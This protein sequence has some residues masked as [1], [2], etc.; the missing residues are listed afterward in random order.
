MAAV[1]LKWKL[2]FFGTADNTLHGSTEIASDVQPEAGGTGSYEDP[3]TM[4]IRIDMPGYTF[5]QKFYVPGLNRY[6]E[7]ADECGD[8]NDSTSCDTDFEL[9][10]GN[11]SRNSAVED[12]EAKLTPDNL[13][14]VIADPAAGLPTDTAP[15]WKDST[16]QCNIVAAH[17][18]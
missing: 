8:N 2:T 3:L 7:Y 13:Q 9:Y 16:Q 11:P 12:C 17:W 14:D 15:L 10:V 1:V 18:S 5:G 4:A 6:F